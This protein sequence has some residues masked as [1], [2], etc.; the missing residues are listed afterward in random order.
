MATYP[1]VSTN[2]S[3]IL[4]KQIQFDILENSKRLIENKDILPIQFYTYYLEENDSIFTI[5][6][7]FNLTYDTIASL[8]N[9]ENQLFFTNKE[10]IIIPNCSGLY[11]ALEKYKNAEQITVNNKVL[12]FYPGRS[13][14]GKERLGFLITPFKSPLKT[15]TVTSEFGNRENPFTQK[16]EFHSGLDLKATIGTNV[17]SPYKGRIDNIG[18]SDFYGNYMI[19][20]HTEGYSSHYYHL[21]S[22]NVS[23]GDWVEKGDF[24]AKTGNSGKSTG[25]HLHLEIHYNDEPINPRILLGDV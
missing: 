9:I 6:S 8:N 22:I 4:Y 20:V 5:S 12:Y 16:N 19:I 21:E 3:D 13:F 23:V 11:T 15:M 25:P 24:V 7:R 14:S 2:N 17:Y 10:N 1:E 18:Y